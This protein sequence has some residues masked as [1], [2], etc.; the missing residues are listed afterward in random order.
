[1]LIFPLFT[2]SGE[3]DFRGQTEVTLQSSTGLRFGEAGLSC[4]CCG[5]LDFGM[6]KWQG[7]SECPSIDQPK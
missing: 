7:V 4:C 2:R 3:G 1:M 5:Y 6:P